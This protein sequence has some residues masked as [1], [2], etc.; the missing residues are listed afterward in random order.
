MIAKRTTLAFGLVL[1]GL[2]P[3]RAEPGTAEEATRLTQ[4]FESYVGANAAG[5]PPKVAVAAEADGYR[6]TVNLEQIAAPLAVHGLKVEPA[7]FSMRI[8]RTPDGLWRLFDATFPT[9]D[10]TLADSRSRWSFTKPSGESLFDPALGAV[11]RSTVTIGRIESESQDKDGQSRASYSDYEAVSTAVA[12]GPDAVT[13]QGRDRFRDLSQTMRLAWPSELGGGSTIELGVTVASQRSEA[14]IEALKVKPLLGI[15]RL[16]VAKGVTPEALTAA[17][18]DLRK[19]V[20]ESLP[21][22]QRIGGNSQFDGVALQF[23]SGSASMSK[24]QFGID[25]NGLVKP[26]GGGMTLQATDLMVKST[27]IPTWVEPLI[28]GMID[29]GFNTGGFDF[30]GAARALIDLADPATAGDDPD[31]I[32]SILAEKIMPDGRFTVTLTPGRL[33][34]S[35]YEVAWDGGLEVASER[36]DG[37]ITVRAI[38]LDKTIAALGAAKGDK[39]AAGALV[40]LYGAQALA[41]PDTDGALKWVVRFKPDGSILV[42]DNVVQ[43]PTEEAVPEEKDDDADGDGQDGKAAKP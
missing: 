34:S 26:A 16:L 15:W 13:L 11:T 35:L 42:N 5:A 1:A 3:V 19:A 24:L 27:V 18:D 38:G 37:T 6:V 30:D 23:P 4:L 28:P 41:A 22:F 12:A 8:A 20:T 33:R 10:A 9:F 39:I 32:P 7:P 2:M 31:L 17:K 43:K 40:G 36:V 29:I 25:L 21:V 14:T